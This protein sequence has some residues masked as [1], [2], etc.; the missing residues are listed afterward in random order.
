MSIK[1]LITGGSS[2]IGEALAKRLATA[3]NQIYITGRSESKLQKISNEINEQNAECFY[4]AGD[5]ASAADVHSI[6]ADAISKMGGLD[7]LIANAGTGRFGLI[8]EMSEEDFDVQFNTNV[9]GVFL[10]IK[11]A[12]KLMKEKNAGQIIV[13]SSNLGLR[14]RSQCALY[15]ATKFAIQGMVGSI[16]EELEDTKVKV[17]IINPGAVDTPWF[18]NSPKD[19][20]T[21]LD[22]EEVVDALML[23]INQ[24]PRSNIDHIHLVPAKTW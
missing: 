14:V 13:T 23:I 12:I 20:A 6:F 21:M 4:M 17:A 24:G 2:G 19:K 15:C 7:V 5:V 9:K 18:A 1:I 8:E 22:V 11:E 16:R 3:N 10:F